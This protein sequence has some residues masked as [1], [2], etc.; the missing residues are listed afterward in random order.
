MTDLIQKVETK[1]RRR[2][3]PEIKPGMLVRVHYKIKEPKRET[4]QA[5][6]GLVIAVK[7]GRGTKG[8]FTVRGEAAGQMVEKTYPVHSPLIKKIEILERYKVRRNK[9]YFIRSL[10]QAKL[11]KKLKKKIKAK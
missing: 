7:H 5:F 2:D 9:L 10:S 11:R 1:Y 8:M 3:L 6:Q 4:T